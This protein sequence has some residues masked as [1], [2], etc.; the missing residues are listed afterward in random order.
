MK[1]DI[2]VEPATTMKPSHIV[3]CATIPLEVK[4][5]CRQMD[6]PV[7][8]VKDPVSHGKFESFN[9]TVLVSGVGIHRM[10]RRLQQTQP[11]TYSCWVSYGFAGALSPQCGNG[12]VY[13]GN[14]VQYMHHD[15]Y[16]AEP[17]PGLDYPHNVAL[18]CHG[19]L[20]ATVEQKTELHL[21]TGASLVDMESY[22]VAVMAGQRHEPFFWLRG[23]S[24]AYDEPLP[25]ELLHCLDEH[26]FP[27]VWKS[28]FK[29]CRK[30]VLLPIA[31]SLGKKAVRL[32][33]TIA[34]KTLQIMDQLNQI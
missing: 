33:Q 5:L 1:A 18:L 21:T 23:V 8:T 11:M 16:H 10:M 13:L 4:S 26:G 17:L 28:A 2:Y 7:P 30:P 32:Q 20:A 14:T 31:F 9:V 19:E 29:L 27:S 6:M 25:V 15:E 22:A 34:T 24:D 3:F 12:E